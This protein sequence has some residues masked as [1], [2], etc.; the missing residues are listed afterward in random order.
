MGTAVVAGPAE[1]PGDDPFASG[2][3]P[4]K[5]GAV[6]EFGVIIVTGAGT[7]LSLRFFLTNA[8]DIS[9]EYPWEEGYLSEK[10]ARFLFFPD[11]YCAHID[12]GETFKGEV[13]VVVCQV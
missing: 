10:V 1:L 5:I 13:D 7:S 12:I 4:V 2:L 11:L 8:M 3:A 9:Y 6:S